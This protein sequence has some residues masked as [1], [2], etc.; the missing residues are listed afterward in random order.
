M[1][2]NSI[3]SKF[4]DNTSMFHLIDRQDLCLN[5]PVHDKTY[6]GPPL[7]CAA[8]TTDEVKLKLICVWRCLKELLPR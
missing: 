5:C 8:R 7:E 3:P 6:A 1:F 2:V 4:I